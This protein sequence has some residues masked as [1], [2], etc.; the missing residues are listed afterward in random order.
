MY[1][2][3]KKKFDSKKFFFYSPIRASAKVQKNL[4]CIQNWL[5]K[6]KIEVNE[7]KSVHITFT[8]KKEIC[9]N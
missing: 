5:S 2:N 6:W 1:S 4:N 9:P 7:L 3:V 8:L